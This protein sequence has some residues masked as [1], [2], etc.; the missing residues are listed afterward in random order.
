MR[1]ASR[2]SCERTGGRPTT[3][4]RLCIGARTT[5]LTDA[6]DRAATR[7]SIH[8]RRQRRTKTAAHTL[9][10]AG[11]VLCVS[12]N[13]V[14]TRTR[15]LYVRRRNIANGRGRVRRRARPGSSRPNHPGDVGP[16]PP[17]SQPRSG[18]LGL[19][20]HLL[21]VERQTQPT[22]VVDDDLAVVEANR[23]RMDLP[24]D[25]AGH[26]VRAGVLHLA[27]VEAAARIILSDRLAEISG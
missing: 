11:A 8:R 4:Q 1:S 18:M 26:R 24:R 5:N 12:H 7:S 20:S 9:R 21:V 27:A 25:S 3:A 22:G 10:E 15:E 16:T 6:K 17:K 19:G 23:E 13:A 2:S 14:K